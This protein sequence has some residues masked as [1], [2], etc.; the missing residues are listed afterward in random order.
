M[1]VTP[2]MLRRFDDA[3]L[4]FVAT[5]DGKE[6]NVVPVGFKWTHEGQLL[7]ADLFFGKTRDNIGDG[8]RI[9]VAIG[10]VGPKTGLQF[11]GQARVHRDGPMYDLVVAK[12]VEKG[13]DL[14][15][16][17]AVSVDIT[18]VYGLDPGAEAGELVS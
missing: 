7:I 13:V 5:T 8:C 16:H 10:S 6:P 2:E 1:A 3:A 12:L 4:C 15:L 14:P 9:A 11:K 17:A 18:E